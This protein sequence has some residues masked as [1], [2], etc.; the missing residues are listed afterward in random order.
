MLVRVLNLSFSVSNCT[1]EKFR[2]GS[3]KCNAILQVKV[4]AN[5]VLPASKEML[6]VACVYVTK[7]QDC[8]ARNAY[9]LCP[10]ERVASPEWL[11][12]VTSGE[13]GKLYWVCE[14]QKV[15]CTSEKLKDVLQSCQEHIQSS[16]IPYSLNHTNKQSMKVACQ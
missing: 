4:L 13:F 11:E 15:S 14:P 9:E 16:V 7:Y 3:D 2:L 12:N 6:D 1:R 10:L 5:L 8:V